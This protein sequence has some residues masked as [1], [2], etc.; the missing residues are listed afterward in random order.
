VWRTPNSSTSGHL[1][2]DKALDLLSTLPWHGTV[3]GFDNPE[4]LYELARYITSEWFKDVHQNQMLDILCCNLMLEPGNLK[5]E[6]ENL[7]FLEKLKT[8]Y[9]RRNTGEYESSHYFARARGLGEALASGICDS[10]GVEANIENCHW[11]SAVIDF[12]D[13]QILYDDSIG[14]GPEKDFIDTVS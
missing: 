14:N 10:V 3:S 8:A 7:D 13:G 11:V 12:R 1:L 6:I 4:P 5:K 9:K 2:V